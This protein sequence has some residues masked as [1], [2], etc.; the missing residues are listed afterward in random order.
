MLT[1]LL[2]AMSFAG[3]RTPISLHPD[4]P[5]YFLFRGKPTVLIT[6]GEHYG[7]V[8]NRDFDY[9]P[10]LKELQ[11][12]R[13]N[14]TRIFSG[15][16][17]EDPKSF[18]IRDNTLAPAPGRFL[19]PWRR[20]ATP[21]YANGG[22]KFDL[23]RWDESYFE[24]LKS[25]CT[26]AGSRGVVVEI[27][28]F[29][30]F[31]EQS[32]WNLSPLNAKNNVNGVGSCGREEVYALKHPDVTQA[33]D[34]MTAKVVDELAGFDNVFFEICNEPYFGGVT[35]AWQ[36]H[37]SGVIAAVERRTGTRHLIAQNIANG[38]AKVAD[39][40]P[41][42]SVFNFHYAAP[43]DAVAENADLRRAIGFD[44]TGFKG[45]AD[46]P[47]RTEGWDFLMAGGALYNNLDYSYTVKSPQGEAVVTPPTPGG[48][49]PELRRQLAVLAAFFHRL[50]FVKMRPANELV[51]GEMPKGVT[52]RVL[53]EPGRVTALYIKGAGAELLSLE[54]PAGRYTAEWIHPV[55]GAAESGPALTHPGGR[56]ELH[57]P[58]YTEDLALRLTRH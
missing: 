44:E 37:I 56:L 57:V 10:Y 48:G 54:L 29:C 23:N 14:Y 58:H 38:A 42:V 22:D 41:E 9:G 8:L 11:H 5:H 51:S 52:V 19:C 7:A 35:L 40:D 3:A 55:S 49:G 39:A 34:A 45:S 17:C 27:S 50:D 12:R 21:G 4:N 13:F 32:M 2:L 20:A 47:Y 6:S 26:E 31:Y 30:P 1:G 43:P 16:Y 15:P 24:R 18:N 46:L 53:A 25:F 28:L 33:Q 36:R